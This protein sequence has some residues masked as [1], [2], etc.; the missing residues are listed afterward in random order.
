MWLA[1][2]QP[3]LV[4]NLEKCRRYTRRIMMNIRKNNPTSRAK[5]R[6]GFNDNISK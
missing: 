1:D 2:V 4:S 3:Q 5:T 6:F